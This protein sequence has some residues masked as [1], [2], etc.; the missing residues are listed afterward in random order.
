MS[1]YDSH[2]TLPYNPCTCSQTTVNTSTLGAELTA[3]ML[4]RDSQKPGSCSRYIPGFLLDIAGLFLSRVVQMCSPNDPGGVPAPP[5]STLLL[6]R[7]EGSGD[8][9]AQAL[10]GHSNSSGPGSAAAFNL[11]EGAWEDESDKGSDAGPPEA[12]VID[13]LAYVIP[14]PRSSGG[15]A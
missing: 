4:L 14:C 1:T 8:D 15:T 7:P 5:S 9:K 10:D 6:S 2:I 13:P 11:A 12:E 3:A